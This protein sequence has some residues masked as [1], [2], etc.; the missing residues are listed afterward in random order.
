[1]SPDR[2]PE[3]YSESGNPVYKYESL[4]RDS[5]EPVIGDPDTS[6]IIGD[7]ISR[8]FEDDDISV[9]HEIV[10]DK[11]HV[12]IFLIKANKERD[13]HILMTSG[14]SSLPMNVPSDL[15]G[16]EYAEVVAL[17]PVNWPLE[18][19]A[20]EDENNYWP[21]RQL[22]H[23]ARFPHMYDTWV[24]EGHTITNGNPP[25]PMA[26]KN[27]FVG[28]VLLPSITLPEDFLTIESNGQIINVYSMIPL[29]N[30]E[31][32]FKLKYGTDELLGKFQ[33][34]DIKE[35]ID[36]NRPNTCKKRFGLF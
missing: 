24:G 35:I 10:S 27:D 18:Q 23:L 14:M 26:D 19:K 22:K 13:Y 5:I 16:L 17:L 12:D 4:K 8:F 34:F 20:F 1:M 9:F 28:I 15:R 29:Y 25:E 6:E 2:K 36:I 21:I 30:E 7:H 3:K 33:K 11:I 31:M 32:D